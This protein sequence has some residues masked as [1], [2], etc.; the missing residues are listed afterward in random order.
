MTSAGRR[1]DCPRPRT[2]SSS[3]QTTMPRRSSGLI[4]QL[5]Y[6]EI[7]RRELIPILR[8]STAKSSPK[9]LHPS[10]SLVSVKQVLDQP[11]RREPTLLRAAVDAIPQL[12]RNLDRRH[13]HNTSIRLG[14]PRNATPCA[15]TPNG[16]DQ[17]AVLTGEHATLR[18]TP[19][20]VALRRLAAMSNRVA[21]HRLD[22]SPHHR[23]VYN[24][25]VPNRSIVGS[26]A[27]R[28]FAARAW[29]GRARA[30]NRNRSSI[31]TDARRLPDS[32]AAMLVWAT[33]D[34]KAQLSLTDTS[35]F[36]Q[37]PNLV[38]HRSTISRDM[39]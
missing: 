21:D 23:Q 17:R 22:I 35:R 37:P 32:Y 14:I 28:R 10:A 16:Q 34:L 5:T 30:A 26:F 27:V 13:A 31:P 4:G 19:E 18:P 15:H 33:P 29:L 2:G 24:E 8:I 11:C 39:T 9:R 25:R 12:G 36:P 20:A 6:S 1:P 7:P 3:A 38:D